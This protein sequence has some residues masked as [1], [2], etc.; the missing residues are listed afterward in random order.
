MPKLFTHSEIATQHSPEKKY[1]EKCIQTPRVDT[2]FDGSGTYDSNRYCN[3]KYASTVS[4]KH[5]CILMF[6]KCRQTPIYDTSHEGG[7]KL[8]NRSLCLAKWEKCIR[9]HMKG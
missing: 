5:R 2:S 9:K 4:A 1:F 7:G 3:N 8:N 6:E